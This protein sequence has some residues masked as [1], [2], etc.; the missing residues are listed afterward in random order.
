MNTSRIKH[1][2]IFS[3]V[4]SFRLVRNKS[5]E[6]L[7]QHRCV[8]EDVPHLYLNKYLLREEED[9]PA[10]EN[11]VEAQIL[12]GVKLLDVEEID[13]PSFLKPTR[14]REE[15]P[16]CKKVKAEIKKRYPEIKT[17]YYEG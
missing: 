17:G 2:T 9:F 6:E 10:F 16:F 5:P 8:W 4:D 13:F 3:R 15:E 14:Y 7:N 12:G 11:Y 1:R